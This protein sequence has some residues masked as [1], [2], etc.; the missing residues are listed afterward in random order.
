MTEAHN[1]NPAQRE[2]GRGKE[3]LAG[4]QGK[5]PENFFSLTPAPPALSWMNATFPD[6]K[7]SVSAAPFAT[8]GSFRKKT[9]PLALLLWRLPKA[10]AWSTT[11][12]VDEL[13]ADPECLCGGFPS[14]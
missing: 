3:N 14:L 9:A 6:L 10:D 8:L 2:P 5:P 11:V 4:P 1:K 12:L 7:V 13:D